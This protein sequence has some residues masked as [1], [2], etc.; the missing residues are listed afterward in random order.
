MQNN[1]RRLCGF[2]KRRCLQISSGGEEK[3][4]SANDANGANCAS[5]ANAAI[6]NTSNV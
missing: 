3:V 5:A 2:E 1:R 6:N 4:S